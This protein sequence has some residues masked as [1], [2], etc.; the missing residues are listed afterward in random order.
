MYNLGLAYAKGEGVSPD[1]VSAHTWFNLAAA[2]FPAS[3]IRSRSMAIKNRDLVA[4]K[5]T[6]EEIEEAQKLARKSVA[7]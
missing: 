5:M 4:T 3:D 7:Q 2:S 6:L 1:N